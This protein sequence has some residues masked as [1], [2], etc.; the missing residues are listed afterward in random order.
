MK[1]IRSWT[2]AAV[3]SAALAACGGGSGGDDPPPARGT[4]IIGELGG[5]ATTDQINQGTAAAH[6]N[7]LTGA[8]VCDVDVHYVVYMTRDPAGNPATASTAVF[9]PKAPSGA[10]AAVQQQCAGNSGQAPRVLYAHGTTTAKSYNIADIKATGVDTTTGLPVY[11][12]AAGSEGSLLVAMYAAQGFVVIAPNYLGY[13][14]SSLQYHPYLN[15][16]AQAVDMVDGLRAADAYLK[17][18]TGADQSGK[19]FITGYSQ[20]GYVAMATD[21]IIGRDYGSEFTV[22]GSVPMSGPYNLVGFGD[23]VVTT[24]RNAGATIFVPLQIESYQNAYGNVYTSP[25]DVYHSPYDTT[26]PNLFPTDTPLSTLI[27][28]PNN[29]LPADPTFTALFSTDNPN[30]YLLTDS[31]KTS[32]VAALQGTGTSGY[33][34]D[35]VKNTLVGQDAATG[36]TIT[37]APAHPMMLCGGANDPTV[38][39]APNGGA[40]GQIFAGAGLQIPALDIENETLLDTVLGTQEGETVYQGFQGAKAAAGSNLL[41][42]Y[43][44]TLVPPFCNAIARGFFSTLLAAQ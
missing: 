35:L 7:A 38:F 44:G 20:G 6:I 5:S 22:A 28:P 9:L 21:K 31:F 42:E 40:A 19:L 10:S 13:D 43:H 39:W 37:W 24:A 2:L 23:A 12:N 14:V 30:D 3:A 41:A 36:T 18:A 16:E 17:T 4:V 26:A 29:K 32:Y 25:S 33:R 8:A 11:E 34:D 27:T 1:Y 15:A